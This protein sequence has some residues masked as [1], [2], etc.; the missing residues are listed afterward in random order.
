MLLFTFKIVNNPCTIGM[1]RVVLQLATI[2]WARVNISGY[3]FLLRVRR[4]RFMEGCGGR[5]HWVK[6]DSTF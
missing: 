5:C 6:D 2:V 4:R 1:M 3:C